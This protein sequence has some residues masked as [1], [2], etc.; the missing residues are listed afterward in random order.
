MA[1][2]TKQKRGSAM[3]PSAPYRTWASDPAGAS[4]SANRMALMHFA[5]VAA[6]AVV[7][8]ATR[9]CVTIDDYAKNIVEIADNVLNSVSITDHQLNSVVIANERC[10]CG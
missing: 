3:L 1:L 2:D 4:T 9:G 6:A 10:C 8:V 5:A 7:V